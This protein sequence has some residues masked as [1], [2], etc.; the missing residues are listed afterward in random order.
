MSIDERK[1]EGQRRVG[2]WA[3]HRH[4]VVCAVVGSFALSLGHPHCRRVICT[5]VVSSEQSLGHPNS[6]WANR[7]NLSLLAGG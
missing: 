5:V 4:W 3:G 7:L 2:L 1:Q 6:R